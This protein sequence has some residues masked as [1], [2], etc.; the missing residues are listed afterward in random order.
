M[1]LVV[2]M[3]S[4]GEER[5]AR[6]LVESLRAFG[7]PMRG[8]PVWAFGSHGAAIE[9]IEGVRALPL[10][11]DVRLRGY[12][13]AAKASACAAAES[14]ARAEGASLVFMSS[15]C[16]IVNPP[17]LLDLEPPLGASFRPVHI[18]NVG[19]PAGDPADAFWSAVLET[20]GAADRSFTIRSLVD[21]EVLRPYFNT[22]LFSVDPGAGLLEEWVEHFAA[23]VQD[24]EFQSGPCRDEEHKI[25]LHQAV[26]SALAAR[27]L[28]PDRIRLLPPDYSYPLHFHREVPEALR[29]K[30]L[31][32][33]VCP[34]YEGRYEH[35]QTLHGIEVGDRLASWLREHS[36]A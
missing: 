14:M 31:D 7:G 20:V 28:G 1:R 12:A 32:E 24:D 19:S 35:P 27:A 29:P 23:M 15:A 13:F 25:F 2:T 36:T 4:A 3:G 26:L 16:L 34:V 10:D 11:V 5:G 21:S 33:L 18:A 8:C 6:L 30:S 9:S 22:H 17:A